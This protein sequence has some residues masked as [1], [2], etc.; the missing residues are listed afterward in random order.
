MGPA[1]DAPKWLIR[2]WDGRM[3]CR[4]PAALQP[5]PFQ[6]HFHALNQS[7]VG[8]KTE[9]RLKVKERAAEKDQ[10]QLRAHFPR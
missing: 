6:V 10:L 9:R 2:Q 5:E 3:M 8:I 4:L 1:L 7:V